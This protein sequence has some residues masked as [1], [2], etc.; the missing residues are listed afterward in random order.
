MSLAVRQLLPILHILGTIT[1]NSKNIS[2]SV[3]AKNSYQA[4]II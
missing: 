2:A 3:T 1:G 4:V